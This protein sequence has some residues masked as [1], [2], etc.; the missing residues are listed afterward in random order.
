M[1]KPPRPQG[2][3]IQWTAKLKNLSF[4]GDLF[5]S[6]QQVMHENLCVENLPKIDLHVM[7]IQIYKKKDIY[8]Y[9]Y[10][11]IFNYIYI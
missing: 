1:A 3:A 4:H 6:S 11:C 5:F 8:L 10:I 9:K 2:M 7:L